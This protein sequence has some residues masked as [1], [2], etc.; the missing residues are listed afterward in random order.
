MSLQK[1]FVL[2]PIDKA[3]N[4]VLIICKRYYVEVVLK[5]I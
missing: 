2:T 4:N 5:E 1:E 3:S